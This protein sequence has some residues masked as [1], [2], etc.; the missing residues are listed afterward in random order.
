MK[1]FKLSIIA[2][3]V[4]S[5]CV[6]CDGAIAPSET[7]EACEQYVAEY[8]DSVEKMVDELYE[9]YDELEYEMIINNER[10]EQEIDVLL[11]DTKKAI[12][13]RVQQYD[14]LLSRYNDVTD[15]LQMVSTDQVDYNCKN[16]RWEKWICDAYAEKLTLQYSDGIN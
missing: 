2:M 3:T 14:G 11:A 5:T 10:S 16:G 7:T 8:H 4:I 13:I 15:A 12:D 9:E 1:N 6:A